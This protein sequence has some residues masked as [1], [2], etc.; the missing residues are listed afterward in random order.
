M[1]MLKIDMAQFKADMAKVREAL[2]SRASMAAAM[3]MKP[4]TYADV[5]WFYRCEYDELVEERGPRQPTLAERELAE[6]HQPASIEALR[7]TMNVRSR[8]A[9]FTAAAPKDQ[10]RLCQ[11]AFAANA[12]LYDV[13]GSSMTF[14]RTDCAV[15]IRAY[16]KG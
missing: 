13:F 14:D 7:N 4:M 6:F 9:Q 12:S 16:T 11:M 3:N 10:E 2:D 1:T 5:R 8:S 15:M